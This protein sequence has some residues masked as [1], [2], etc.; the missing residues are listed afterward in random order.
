ME[1]LNRWEY[2]LSYDLVRFAPMPED[3]AIEDGILG[4]DQGDGEVG[5]MA[6]IGKFFASVGKEILIAV[7]IWAAEK[8]ARRSRESYT[9]EKK[10]KEMV[11]AI[12][13]ARSVRGAR[14][15][16]MRKSGTVEKYLGVIF[17]QQG[18]AQDTHRQEAGPMCAKM[19]RKGDREYIYL[20]QAARRL[21]CKEMPFTF[22]VAAWPIRLTR[23]S[24]SPL[25]PLPQVDFLQRL[26][27]IWF[28]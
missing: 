10:E 15:E 5:T 27:A 22:L 23:C 25:F 21:H 8:G 6:A 2:S 7:G 4:P 13:M 1:K 20:S 24:T 11:E 14:L 18:M 9:Q 26:G 16:A 28:S 12:D 19:P 3:T 17:R